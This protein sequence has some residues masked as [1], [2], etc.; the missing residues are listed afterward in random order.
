[1]WLHQGAPTLHRGSRAV[2][3]RRTAAQGSSSRP[4]VAASWHATPAPGHGHVFAAICQHQGE[5]EDC[6]HANPRL[7]TLVC[8][9]LP[10]EYHACCP[11]AAFKCCASPLAT[12]ALVMPALDCKRPAHLA[13]V[14]D[15]DGVL[16]V[17]GDCEPDVAH[18]AGTPAGCAG[19][20]PHS[21]AHPGL[22]DQHALREL[23]QQLVPC[24]AS[25]QGRSAHR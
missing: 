9:Q 20:H 16:A 15:V 22:A 21:V 19:G 12:S 3:A 18:T 2:S 24:R 5:P 10:A 7:Q 23:L 14:A 4:L 13:H 17:L 25:K 1:M 11:A 6:L 8:R